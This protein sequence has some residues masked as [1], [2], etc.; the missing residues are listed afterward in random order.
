VSG[1]F[2]FAHAQAILDA[3]Y[4]PYIYFIGEEVTQS[5]RYW[6]HGYDI[7]TPTKVFIFH[8]Y[9]DAAV[10]KVFHWSDNFDWH[11]RCEI[12]SRKRVLHLL[13]YEKTED[14]VV[15]REIGNYDLGKVRSLE[16][17]QKFADIDFAKQIMGEKAKAGIA[18]LDYKK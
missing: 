1:G 18:N 15:L 4:D 2:I 5:V 9:G 10:D 13:G 3:P 8:L 12:N 11:D 6:T 14:I 7:F 17:Y 16:E